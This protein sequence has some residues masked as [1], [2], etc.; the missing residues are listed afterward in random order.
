MRSVHI[1]VI[2]TD[3]KEGGQVEGWGGGGGAVST[4]P[5]RCLLYTAV[6]AYTGTSYHVSHCQL[7]AAACVCDVSVSTVCELRT[8]F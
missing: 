1:C 7:V 8:F 2:Y 5:D 6:A 3:H 4:W